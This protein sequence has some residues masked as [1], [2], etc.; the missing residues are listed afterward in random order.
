[1]G[2]F[3][4]VL[5]P[6]LNTNKSFADSFTI[7]QLDYS[8]V[9]N[10]STR[11]SGHK[12]GNVIE[13]YI[14][15]SASLPAK[16]SN[17]QIRYSSSTNPSSGTLKI[18][19]F[20]LPNFSQIPVDSG[21]LCQSSMYRYMPPNT[22]LRDYVIASTTVS[23]NYSQD[24]GV[25]NFNFGS[26]FQITNSGYYYILIDGYYSYFYLLGK[27]ISPYD[28]QEYNLNTLFM[29]QGYSCF[30]CDFSDYYLYT[31][32]GNYL[33]QINYSDSFFQ[34]YYSI[35]LNSV[36][37]SA[38]VNIIK[39]QNQTVITNQASTT[40]PYRFE[41]WGVDYYLPD[42]A[43]GTTATLYLD[44]SSFP[45]EKIKYQE[46]FINLPIDDYT[47]STSTQFYFGKTSFLP[48]GDYKAKAYIQ[49]QLAG[50]TTQAII[51]SDD[52]FF[53]ISEL[54]GISYSTSTTSTIPIPNFEDICTAPQGGFLDYPTQNITY[55]LCKVFSYLFIPNQEQQQNIQNRFSSFQDIIKNKPPLG[56]FY[57]I[58]DALN[59]NITA[60]NA[61]TTQV[62]NTS[63]TQAFSAVFSPLKAGLNWVLWLAAG[64]WV[65]IKI[66][67]LNI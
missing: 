8:D 37:P 11:V 42:A 27:R 34:A 25:L 18:F 29:M 13:F 2:L 57:K 16:L 1:L 24:S 31:P 4:G 47:I 19:L 3:L 6:F 21:V 48:N 58:K 65:F 64:S 39:P 53:S 36:A 50:T 46:Q 66:K 30:D 60:G 56:Y 14:P 9:A 32:Y 7:G 44:Y 15:S 38:F 61:T 54:G 33:T 52:V 12:N 17:F 67:N 5:I 63:T 41:F 62:L 59:Q 55:A 10:F 28:C 45:D 26:D 49:Y 22:Y 43:T 40:P 23:Y 35:T 51:Y 20:A